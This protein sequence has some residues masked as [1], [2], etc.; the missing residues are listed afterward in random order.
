[1]KQHNLELFQAALAR[2]A[3]EFRKIEKTRTIKLVSNLDADGIS[4]A[5]IMIRVM[6]RLNLTYSV[7]ILHQLKD[8]NAKDAINIA[9][10]M[11]K[12]FIEVHNP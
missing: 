3:E 6:E 5:S 4:A 11:I 7:T 9:G 8:E 1:M 12:I 2:A 10:R